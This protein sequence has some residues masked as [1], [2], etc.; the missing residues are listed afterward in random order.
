MTASA[1]I[2]LVL[3]AAMIAGSLGYLFL[4]APASGGTYLLGGHAFNAA[5]LAVVIGAFQQEGLTG[6]TVEG[7]QVRVPEAD[8][9]R[10]MAVLAENDT[11]PRNF[12]GA[13]DKVMSTRTWLTTS[14][15]MDRQW[16]KAKKQELSEVFKKMRYVE[17]AYVDWEHSK[18]RGLRRSV[19][20][21]ATVSIKPLFGQTLPHKSVRGIRDMV[22]GMVSGL[23]PED[24][25]VVDMNTGESYARAGSSGVMDN[26]ALEI[27]KGFEEHY[28]E[29][30]RHVLLF[31]PGATVT[32]NVEIDPVRQR[33]RTQTEVS[34]DP[35]KTATVTSESTTTT[36]EET[37]GGSGGAEPGVASNLARPR[38]AST[39]RSG[40]TSSSESSEKIVEQYRPSTSTTTE[41]EYGGLPKRVTVAIGVP[42][43]FYEEAWRSTGKATDPT[44]VEIKQLE[45]EWTTK[46]Q[47]Q[48]AMVI[49][50]GANT[51]LDPISVETFLPVVPREPDAG[52]STLDTVFALANRW[53]GSIGLGVLALVSLLILRS[54]VGKAP[55]MVAAPAPVLEELAAAPNLQSAMA[56][57]GGE[58]EPEAPTLR[59]RLQHAVDEDPEM[60]AGVLQ[61]WIETGK[62][63]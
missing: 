21:T 51:T 53:A 5:E 23:Q 46:I 35:K 49:P 43:S 40:A 58:A 38:V 44:D 2:T 45:Q 50:L 15:D 36:T 24:V 16:D 27:I 14:R 10:Y 29:K 6:F 30:V 28:T 31:V 34:G 1:R 54:M 55:A 57:D 56:L 63:K 39:G 52:P 59:D 25:T 8:V 3:L 26:E 17:D 9:A 13:Y 42:R 20:V 62:R 61:R 11:M 37:R 22:S 19:K 4:V 7:N 41:E 18:T 60:A 33:Q 32:V 12:Y 48:V 47:N